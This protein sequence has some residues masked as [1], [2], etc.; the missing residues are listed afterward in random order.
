MACIVLCFSNPGTSRYHSCLLVELLGPW[1][2][3]AGFC[4]RPPLPTGSSFSFCSF[5]LFV[6]V[7]G[8]KKVID[9]YLPSSQVLSLSRDINAHR[10]GGRRLAT[11]LKI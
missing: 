2:R 4:G 3:K 7:L 8:F 6:I 5:T 11:R 1:V 9:I 10:T